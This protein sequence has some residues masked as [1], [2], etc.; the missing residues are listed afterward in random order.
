MF[1]LKVPEVL[2]DAVSGPTVRVG[3]SDGEIWHERQPSWVSESDEDSEL[4]PKTCQ[5]STVS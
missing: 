5:I 1:L 2:D 3:D 4:E